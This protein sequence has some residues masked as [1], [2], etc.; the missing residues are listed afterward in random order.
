MSVPGIT[1]GQSEKVPQVCSNPPCEMHETS[2]TNTPTVATSNLATEQPG[3][4][5]QVCPNPQSET[6][7]TST[8]HTPTTARQNNAPCETHQ[9]VST[10]TTM[11]LNTEFSSDS[12]RL[13]EVENGS[14]SSKKIKPSTPEETQSACNKSPFEIT[15]TTQTATTARSNIHCGPSENGQRSEGDSCETHQAS[16][17]HTTMSVS[18]DNQVVNPSCSNPPCETH[19]TGTTNTATTSS[20]N[21]GAQQGESSQQSS[22]ASQ[23]STTPNTLEQRVCSNPPCET[24]ETNTTNTSTTSTSNMG[25]NQPPAQQV[26][27][28]PPC[29][30]HETGTTH[31]ATTVTAN[32]GDNQEPPAANGQGEQE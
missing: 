17:T 3:S 21:I 6:R 13:L 29:E 2:T 18:E 25:G 16:S 10:K 30:T 11:S 23:T 22:E 20:S 26:C 9:T 5:A 4:A 14:G 8:T 7:E 1:S 24:H 15:G 32:M 27:S 31:T 28:N 12:K 19:E